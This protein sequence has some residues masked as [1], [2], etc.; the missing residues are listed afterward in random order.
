MFKLDRVTHNFGDNSI[1]LWGWC[2]HRGNDKF[3]FSLSEICV[4]NSSFG[5]KSADYLGF[6]NDSGFSYVGIIFC[7]KLLACSK[8]QMNSFFLL[9]LFFIL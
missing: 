1:Q 2:W 6:L 3:W 5:S 9:G 8:T 4:D 7:R